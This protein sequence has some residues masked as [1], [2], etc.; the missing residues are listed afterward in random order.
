MS[1]GGVAAVLAVFS[2]VSIYGCAGQGERL[3]GTQLADALDMVCEG[4]GFHWVKREEIPGRWDTLQY[5]YSIPAPVDR[6][7]ASA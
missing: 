3:C 1:G 5:R 7:S 2:M 6:T 4:R